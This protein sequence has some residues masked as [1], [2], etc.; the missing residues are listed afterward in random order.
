MKMRGNR[1]INAKPFTGMYQL[2]LNFGA[3]T[4]YRHLYLIQSPI[5]NRVTYT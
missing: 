4:K 3:N 5:L 1:E 2:I